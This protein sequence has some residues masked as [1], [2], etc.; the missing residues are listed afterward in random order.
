MSGSALAVHTTVAELCSVFAK[1]EHDVRAADALLKETTRRLDA[2]FLRGGSGGTGGTQIADLSVHLSTRRNETRVEHIIREMRQRAWRA[3]VER[4]ELRRMMSIERWKALDKQLDEDEWPELTPENLGP[5]AGQFERALPEMREEAVLEVFN[6]LRPWRDEYKT[7]DRFVIGPKLV[8]T[9]AVGRSW[10][11]GRFDIRDHSQQQFIALENV[12]NGLDGKG[13]IAK[14]YYSDLSMALRESP[15]GTGETPLFKFRAFKNGNLHLTM[16][17]PD[18]VSELNKI[19]GGKNL[20][21]ST[22]RAA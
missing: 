13:S 15:S 9:S 21:P 1:A 7:N 22:A 19:A 2:A 8:I 14:G 17:R 4:L 16:K 3:V 6:W 10:G 12:L 18:L 20:R 11:S 5:F